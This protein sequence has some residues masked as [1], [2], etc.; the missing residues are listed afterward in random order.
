MPPGLTSAEAAR[1]LAE[2]GPNIV[3]GKPPVTATAVL[4][5]QFG[6]LVVWFLIAAAGISA[7]IGELLDALA[8]AAIVVLNAVIGFVQEYRAERAIEALRAMTA[9]KARVRRDGQ[10]S[11]IDA[12][13]VV[14]GDLLVIEAGEVVAADGVLLEAHGLSVNE[15]VLTGESIPVEKRVDGERLV[16]MGCAVATGSALVEVTR[17]GMKTE[18]GGIAR[19]VTEVDEE[20]APLRRKVAQLT[21]MLV[22]AS[23]VIV[24][25]IALVSV[26][27]GAPAAEIFLAAVSLAVAAVPEGLPAVVTIALAL[28]V[29]RMAR[30]GV[31]V[32][33]LDAVETLGSTTVI[34]TDKTGTLTTGVMTLR[35][36]WGADH[37]SVIAAAAACCDAE[38]SSDGATGFGDPTEVAIVAAAAKRGIHRADIER[39]N[40]RIETKAFDDVRRRMSILRADG[41]LYVKGAVESVLPLCVAGAEGALDANAA[42]GARGLRVLA[43][44]VGRGGDERDLTF[45]GLLGI[46]DPPR[47]DAVSAVEDARA[48][49]IITVMIT[50]DHAAT[51]R[52]IAV[53][54]GI[55]GP[56]EDAHE[57]V[58]ARVTPKQKLELVRAR[59]AAGAVVAMTGD[60]VNDA[61]ALREAHVGI[62]MGKSGTAVA[63][64][65]ADIVLA[66]DDFASI[67]QAVREGRSV[68]DSIRR[69][70]VYLLSGNV[71]ELGLMLVAALLGWPMP[72]APMQLLWINLVTD[73]LPALGL[74]GLPAQADIMKKSPRPSTEPLLGRRQWSSVGMSAL[75]QVAVCASFFYWILGTRGLTEARSLTFG[76]VVSC[77]LLRALARIGLGRGARSL[78]SAFPLIAIVGAS[79]LGQGALY[80][81]A[82][83][84]KLF[85]L[86]PLAASDALLCI[87]VAAALAVILDLT[88]PRG[89]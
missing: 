85:A 12:R 20:E 73:G 23:C 29:R 84:R 17:T 83:V 82:P 67:V 57:R 71:A 58:H 53:E 55:I 65:A 11:S 31:L 37:A 32:R 9:P 48:A 6:S 28:G 41:K 26:V 15:A 89:K 47:D 24:A 64:E 60:G 68:F 81:F 86:Q 75:L 36:V 4:A 76:L 3:A 13:D 1:R 7:L 35:D 39:D 38:L 78:R 62:A 5:S 80:L 19:M 74:I 27:R 8:I 10:Q 79:L 30:R 18:L 59:K 33:R 40:P 22:I 46:A 54:L 69:S 25:V 45:L 56:S 44:A 14:R 2:D 66:H 88:A 34:C 72:L 52:A 50:G 77:E 63:R 21:R 16:F 70:L 43:I 42:L 51:A 49:G 87:A 61:P